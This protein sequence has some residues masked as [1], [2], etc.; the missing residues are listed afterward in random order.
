MTTGFSTAAT[1]LENISG[2]NAN[3]DIA[4]KD[5]AN[6]P[7]LRDLRAMKDEETKDGVHSFA[8]PRH[9]SRGV[10]GR[11]VVTRGLNSKT[12]QPKPKFVAHKDPTRGK[13]G[14]DKASSNPTSSST[15][16]QAFKWPTLPSFGAPTQTDNPN[17]IGERNGLDSD[18][19]WRFEGRFIFRPSLVR[20]SNEIQPPS[21][22]LLSIFGYSLGG[23]VVLEYDVSPVGPYREYVT[24]GGVVG[25]GK[26]NTGDGDD[27]SSTEKRSLGIGQWGT[28]LYVSTQ[29]AEDV[30]K[31]VWGVPAQVADIEFVESGDVIAD[32]P[33]EE[34][35]NRGGRKFSIEGW[36][37]TRVLDIDESTKRYGNIPIFWTP[38]IKALW[39]PLLLPGLGG[40]VSEEKLLP[41]HKLRLS[42]SAIRL[43]RSQRIQSQTSLDIE[44]EVPLGLALVADNVLI[45]IGERITSG[46][47]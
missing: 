32:G 6:D 23:S 40:G 4:K 19:P 11:N 21:A 3:T 28:N 36:G 1:W 33:D 13:K 17:S 15:S 30:C 31:L 9:D 14:K 20:V 38:T 25:L 29:V 44:G 41:L 5:E 37:N 7:V 12:Q 34:I 45:E 26:V 16:R 24:M 22:N 43:Q 18:Y 46:R 47:A 10:D 27:G 42:A 39:A 8:P 2:P 35:G